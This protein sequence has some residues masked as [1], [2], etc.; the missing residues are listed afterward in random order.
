LSLAPPIRPT[1]LQPPPKDQLQ[2]KRLDRAATPLSSPLPSPLPSAWRQLDLDRGGQQQAL[3]PSGKPLSPLGQCL[4]PAG[5][6]LRSAGQPLR[7]GVDPLHAHLLPPGSSGQVELR[8]PDV[9]AIALATAALPFLVGGHH[10]VLPGS[11]EAPRSADAPRPA[12]LPRPEVLLPPAC[13]Q[14]LLH[15][16]LRRQGLLPLRSC[17]DLNPA[18]WVDLLQR[19][20]LLLPAPPSLLACS[21]WRQA[22]LIAL[23]PAD[24]LWEA[25]WLLVRQEHLAAGWVEELGAG[26]REGCG[27]RGKGG[28]GQGA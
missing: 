25:L 18:V 22:G 28:S 7:L 8:D 6:R 1:H 24:P 21:P 27:G 23:P 16:D 14:P 2:D 13:H 15:A 10:L 26:V 4:S 20:R 17:D 19:E 11:P 9:V 12:S 5:Q 3:F